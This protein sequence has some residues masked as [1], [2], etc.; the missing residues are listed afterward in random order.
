MIICSFVYPFICVHT[1]V[2][3]YVCMYVCVCVCMN[4]YSVGVTAGAGSS[5][6]DTV[7]SNL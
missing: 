2:C 3:M 6:S 7:N 1:C 5:E 4:T